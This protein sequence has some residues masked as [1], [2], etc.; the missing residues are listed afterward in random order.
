MQPS[1]ENKE[2]EKQ[3]ADDNQRRE[4]QTQSFKHFFTLALDSGRSILI[5]CSDV[6]RGKGQITSSVGWR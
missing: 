1:N 2:N 4:K 6:V 5:V 3:C